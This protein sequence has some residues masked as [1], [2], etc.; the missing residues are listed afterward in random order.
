[1]PSIVSIR[2]DRIEI[3]G[4]TELIIV[5]R[6]SIKFIKS[7]ISPTDPGFS[8]CTYKGNLDQRMSMHSV[9]AA[10]IDS[11]RMKSRR[12]QIEYLPVLIWGFQIF[13]LAASRSMSNDNCR[14]YLIYRKITVVANRNARLTSGI[15]FKPCSN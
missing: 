15:S 11:Y 1:M 4:K 5:K 14:N 6:R 3:N 2:R 10:H 9:E 7:A 8:L 13:T 12:N